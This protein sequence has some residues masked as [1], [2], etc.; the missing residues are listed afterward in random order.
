MVSPS[1]VKKTDTQTSKYKTYI[2]FKYAISEMLTQC[3]RSLGAGE[4]N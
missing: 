3:D 1:L 2:L 4:I